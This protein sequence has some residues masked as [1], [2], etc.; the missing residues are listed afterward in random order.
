MNAIT[1]PYCGIGLPD[2]AIFCGECAHQVR[3]RSCRD[4]LEPKARACVMCGA[5]LSESII[6]TT[7]YDGHT[8]RSGINTLEFDE[9]RTGRSLRANLTDSAVDSLSGPLGMFVAGHLD[10]HRQRS[11]GTH[12]REAVVIDNEPVALPVS[13]HNTTE[14][15]RPFIVT[16]P[17]VAEV[18]D[19]DQ[20]RLHGIFAYDGQR[21]R[22]KGSQLKANS[23][24]DFVRRLVCL[25]L[26]AHELEGRDRIPRLDLN[27]I[28]TE[29]TVYDGNSRSWIVNTDD[30]LTNDSMVGLSVPGREYAISVLGQISDP[31]VSS[32]WSLS[33]RSRRTGARSI[34]TSDGEPEDVTKAVRRRSESQSKVVKEWVRAWKALGLAVSMHAVLQDKQWVDRAIVGLWAIRRATK[35][36]I[37]AVSRVHLAQFI[38]EAFEFKGNDRTIGNA[39]EHSPTA[40]NK[41]FKATKTKFQIQPTGMDYAEQLIGSQISAPVAVNGS[42]SSNGSSSSQ[43]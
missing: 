36:E 27:A 1:C 31:S 9:N 28:L 8:S 15:G 41:V 24:R 42:L 13:V 11:H 3:C 32:A 19:T 7:I 30:M 39:L 23:Q 38:Q 12:S 4:M 21:L 25:F 26:Y 40:K 14:P 2:R 16:E 10:I 43:T 33:A 34:I 37:K 29:A 6:D 18:E 17:S 5:L 22:L 35:D 20:D